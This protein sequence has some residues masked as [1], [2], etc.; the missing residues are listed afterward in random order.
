[1]SL[2]VSGSKFVKVYDTE[3]KLQVSDK[4]VFAHLSSSRKTGN[5]RVDSETGEILMD[6]EGN[7]LPERRF[8]SWNAKFVGNA[9]EPSKGLSSGQAIN[10]LS[11]WITNE[12]Y[13]KKDGGTGY[14]VVVTIADFEVCDIVDGTDG[15]GTDNDTDER[16]AN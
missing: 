1:M 12:P 6:G 5:D 15:N 7:P 13:K 11:G 8:S 14:S 10:I 3:I 4:I 16:N 2:V 9:F